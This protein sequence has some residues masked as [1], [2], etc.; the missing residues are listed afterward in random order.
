[1]LLALRL[2]ER[3]K[4]FQISGVFCLP[5]AM[6]EVEAL[7]MGLEKTKTGGCYATYIAIAL[8]GHHG[9]TF[10]FVGAFVPD[11]AGTDGTSGEGDGSLQLLWN[12]FLQ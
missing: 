6:Y 8:S 7:R 9:R 5:F 1:L 2:E 11:R 4:K 10:S 12:R 3:K